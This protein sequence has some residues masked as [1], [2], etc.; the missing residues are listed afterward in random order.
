MSSA[1]LIQAEVERRLGNRFSAAFGLR[2][3]PELPVIPT[4]IAAFDD[5]CGGIPCGAV[6][7]ICG[8]PVLSTGSTSF[9][10]SLLKAATRDHFCSL[11]DSSDSFNVRWADM[12]GV[13]LGRLLWVRCQQR[14]IS[15]LDQ[16]L[17][18]TDLLLKAN[19]GFGL[20]VVDLEDMPEKLV[21]RIPLDVWYRFRLATE[22]LKTALVI[23]T[24]APVT[25]TCSALTLR[26]RGAEADWQ[27][28]TGS[29][30]THTNLLEK[31]VIE[32]EVG[33]ARESKKNIEA[34]RINFASERSLG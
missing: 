12:S 31:F 10:M 8:N 1:A 15:R 21:R 13:Q 32:M 29:S 28:T 2:S 34:A 22:Q 17:K 14:P 7:E 24:P 18:S 16:A 3:R 33:R 6:T 20:I 25:G 30:Y 19:C 11:I 5:L 23:S 27:S 26:L 4:G 9:L